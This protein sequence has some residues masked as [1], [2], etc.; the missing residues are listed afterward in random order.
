MRRW[1]LSH[2]S[3]DKA[4]A[5]RLKA[6]IE[7]K[8]DDAI[9]FFA[10]SN[11]Q[12]GGP[13]RAAAEAVAEA[14]ALRTLLQSASRSSATSSGSEVMTPWPISQAGDKIVTMPSS[15]MATQALA[16]NGIAPCA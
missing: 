11:L 2:H 13:R 15:P 12:A 14:T 10:P 4:L 8:D 9:V 7:R 6:A 5:E 1:F 16:A 3:Q